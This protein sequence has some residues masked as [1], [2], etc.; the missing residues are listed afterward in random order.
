MFTDDTWDVTWQRIR[1]ADGL[2]HVDI[3]ELLEELA[4]LTTETS[5]GDDSRVAAAPLGR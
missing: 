5:P 1:T 3:P 2:V 4:D